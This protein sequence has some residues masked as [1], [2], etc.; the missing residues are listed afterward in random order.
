MRYPECSRSALA[1]LL[2]AGLLSGCERQA[3]GPTTD[4]P[5]ESAT[6][7]GLDGLPDAIQLAEGQWQGDLDGDGRD[8]IAAVLVTDTGGSGRFYY[9]VLFRQT[10]G[11][12]EHVASQLLGDRVSVDSLG[13]A[14]GVIEIVQLEQGEDDA[15]CCPSQRVERRYELGDD[16]LSLA[17]KQSAPERAWGYLV[18][19]H[20][21]RSFATCGKDREA[22]VVDSTAGSLLANLYEEFAIEPYE[23]VFIDARGRWLG[24][25]S[26]GFGQQFDE[27][28]EITEIYRMEREGWGCKLDIEGLVFRGSGNEPSWRID[29]REDAAILS[30][31]DG[32]L[33]W[34]GSGRVSDE[35]WVFEN[36]EQRIN[37]EYRQEPC[38][39][40][41]SGAW[42][43]HTVEY[44]I[45]SDRF[46]GCAVPGKLDNQD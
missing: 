28:I 3:A 30:S 23:P 16:G 35:E 1:A 31:P 33:T 37:I 2:V 4:S 42:L 44:R 34:T 19:G 25:H 27:T 13:I 17:G 46:S 20:E 7:R 6:L 10:D 32:K 11:V 43:S 38:R 12:L 45:G 26:S 36:G 5:L 14:D 39:D 40:S 41:M 22:W 15:M 29:V 9:L 8:E 24:Q 18:W 21:N